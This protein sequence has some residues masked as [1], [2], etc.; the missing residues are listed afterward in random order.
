MF[1][2]VIEGKEY[3]HEY[4]I[5][6]DHAKIDT[7]TSAQGFYTSDVAL[8]RFQVDV[9][10][11]G[12]AAGLQILLK[13]SA[14]SLF[15]PLISGLRVLRALSDDD[16]APTITDVIISGSSWARD[17]YKASEVQL[18]SRAK[19]R[20]RTAGICIRIDDE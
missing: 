3:L 15:D 17:P 4:A 10:A 20:I 11:A 14:A 19:Q 8:K 12:G 16:E 2:V 5:M 1:D 7:S 6:D 13:P 9:G 18:N